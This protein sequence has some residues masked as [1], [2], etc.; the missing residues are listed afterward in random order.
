MAGK[1]ENQAGE[2]EQASELLIPGKYCSHGRAVAVAQFCGVCLVCPAFFLLAVFQM[3]AQPGG[4]SPLRC[5]FWPEA[6]CVRYKS[7]G[8]GS[9][10]ICDTHFRVPYC[11]ITA[12]NSVGNAG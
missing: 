6:A 1:R 2:M 5:C 10:S 11:I 4:V 8:T 3:T 12:E 7:S 9:I